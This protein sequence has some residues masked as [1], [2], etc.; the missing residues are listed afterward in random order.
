MQ[1][2]NLRFDIALLFYLVAGKKQLDNRFG[3]LPYLS[4][5]VQKP[6]PVPCGVFPVRVQTKGLP[7]HVLLTGAVLAGPAV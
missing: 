5:P 4:G 7:G 1:D 3:M 2:A 6:L